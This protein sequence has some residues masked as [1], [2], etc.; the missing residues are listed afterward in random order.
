[1]IIEGY[2]AEAAAI[3]EAVQP[4]PAP[5]MQDR[6]RRARFW[7]VFRHGRPVGG[8]CIE[9]DCIHVGCQVPCGLEVRQVVREWL[10][11][12]PVLYAPI[13]PDNHAAI[14][15]ALGLGFTFLAAANGFTVYQR[16]KS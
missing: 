16:L 5:H 13:R 8:I 12:K 4:E 11:D 7:A 15:L 9:H 10:R 14:R 2:Y 6:L 3:M 1:M